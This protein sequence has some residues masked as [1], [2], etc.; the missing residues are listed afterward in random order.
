MC[1]KLIFLNVDFFFQFS[2]ETAKGDSYLSDM[3]RI[4]FFGNLLSPTDGDSPE[5]S[6]KIILKCFPANIARRRTFRSETFF[7]NEVNFYKTVLPT[8]LKFQEEKNVKNPFQSYPR[9]FAVFGDGKEDFIA[10][11]DLKFIGYESAKRQEGID[12]AHCLKIIETFSKFHAISFA[13]KDQHPEEYKKLA[14]L[15]PETYFGA[16]YKYWYID[17]WK[18]I[19]ECAIDAVEKEYPNT[20]YEQ[21]IK[22]F[23]KPETYDKLVAA[24][25]GECKS[26]IIGHGD[27]WTPNFLFKYKEGT[28]IPTDSKMLD[29]Q[30]A[31]SASPIVDLV[32]FIYACSTHEIRE[33]HFDDMLKY[34]YDIL[35]AQIREMGTDPDKVYSWED[36]MAEVKKLAYFA[37][38]FCMESVPVITLEPEDA[39]DLD[40]IT[41]S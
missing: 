15:L 39:F 41:V 31:R 25:S 37:V 26:A 3:Y 6:V 27:S 28:N 24:T 4:T 5:V 38:G 21:K 10:M 1:C 11:E 2:K 34:Y 33:E 7:S 19:C 13:F 18:L 12:Y 16:L 23:A 9:I 14:V 40:S 30:I 17:Y 35:S 20:I 22:D 36:F 29:Y 32:F 8:L